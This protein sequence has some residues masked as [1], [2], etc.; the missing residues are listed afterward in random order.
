V[1]AVA[2]VSLIAAD[3]MVASWG[4]NPA[5]DPALL[6]FTPPALEWLQGQD[7]EARAA[8]EGP[9]RIT[10]YDRPRRE[11]AQRQ[12]PVD[13]WLEDVRGYDSIIPKQYTDFMALIAPQFQL[14]Y[15]RVA[16][17]PTDHPEA[18][19]SELLN[20]LACVT[21]SPADPGESGLGACI[22]RPGRAHLR[23]YPG[24]AAR[25]HPAGTGDADLSGF[26]GLQDSDRVAGHRSR[27]RSAG[28]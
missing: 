3:L 12:H 1:W 9:I 25:L 6:E 28:V 2:A 21:W 18:L 11:P 26:R 15:N 27:D 10:T 8:G 17:I 23:E 4:F 24:L 22:R 14:E 16:P 5:A 19:G 20:L 7:A 13:V